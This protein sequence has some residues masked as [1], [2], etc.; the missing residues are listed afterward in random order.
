MDAYQQEHDVAD[1]VIFS[2]AFR[3]SLKEAGQGKLAMVIAYVPHPSA[4]MF[5]MQ[6]DYPDQ[7]GMPGME[8]WM[9]PSMPWM[10]MAAWLF[11]ASLQ[12]E[13]MDAGLGSLYQFAHARE[14]SEDEAFIHH[15]GPLGMRISGSGWNPGA[16]GDEKWGM[17]I[18]VCQYNVSASSGGIAKGKERPKWWPEPL[19]LV[20]RQWR[21]DDPR[22]IS[23]DFSVVSLC[24][25]NSMR[26]QCA[27]AI[28][29]IGGATEADV[30]KLIGVASRM[31]GS[32]AGSF[33]R[34]EHPM[35]GATRLDPEKKANALAAIAQAKAAWEAEMIGQAAKPGC[36]TGAG[37]VRI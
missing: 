30:S 10:G 3:K 6:R 27:K 28:M 1:E 26:S 4:Q 14:A 8:S 17:D 5:E 35:F 18:S 36:S 13:M 29:E 12:K 21:F 9:G 32:L 37:V 19:P 7:G 20:E 25:A 23:P 11:P 24:M 33:G 2:Q 31:D 22:E 15:L 34:Q 16:F